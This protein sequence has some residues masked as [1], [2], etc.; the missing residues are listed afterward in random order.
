[1]IADLKPEAITHQIKDELVIAT[2]FSGRMR[3]IAVQS[4]QTVT[5][6]MRVHDLSPI[7]TIALGLFAIGAQLMA[8]DLKNDDASMSITLRCDGPLGGMVVAAEPTSYVRG[9]AFNPR[10]SL[11]PRPEDG[12]IHFRDAVGAGSLTVVKNL[13][14]REPY[15]GTVDLISGEIA[16]DLAYYLAASE[17]IPSVLA[18][19]VLVNETGVVCAGGLLIQ[20]LPGYTEEDVNYIER[21]AAGFPDVTFW[22]QQGFTASQL[23]DLFFGDKN[24]KYLEQRPIGFCCPCSRERMERNLLAIGKADLIE[25]AEDSNG[26][27]LECHFCNSHYHFDQKE[28]QAL[29]AAKD[30][31]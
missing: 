21:R 11:E 26:I 19:G 3:G 17:Q 5:D 8:G 1:M 16:E 23:L 28:V 22:L 10:V 2:A 14:V 20:L 4:T 30:R 24:L 7:S 9:Y 29:V 12:K 13:G 15:S 25:L 27:N 31:R 18:A 6:L